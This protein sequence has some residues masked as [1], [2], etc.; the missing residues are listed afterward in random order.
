MSGKSAFDYDRQWYIVGRWQD[1]VGE[2]R[3]NVLRVTTIAVF[4]ILQLVQYHVLQL[5]DQ[6]DP[7]FHRAATALAVLGL[8]VSLAVHLCL[9]RHIFPAALKYLS[10][11]TDVLLVT[12]LA[13]VGSGP[14][15]PLRLAFFL[16]IAMAALRSSVTLVWCATLG[17]MIGYLVTV[18]FADK[19]WFDSEH[20][21]RPIEQLMTLATL[22]LTGIVIGQ[23][24]RRSRIMAEDFQKRV[25]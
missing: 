14:H 9:H 20:V 4:Y 1:Y 5:A 25:Q 15:S 19:S 7:A 23:V 21:V 12:C 24:V 16:I 10:V 3:A 11:A 17:T 8:F 22:S 18:G 6:R 2:N 13:A